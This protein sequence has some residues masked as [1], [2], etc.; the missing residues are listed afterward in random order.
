MGRWIILQLYRET[1]INKNFSKKKSNK[2]NIPSQ[3][4]KKKSIGFVGLDF[5]HPSPNIRNVFIPISDS[6]LERGTLALMFFLIWFDLRISLLISHTNHHIIMIMGRPFPPQKKL[7]KKIYGPA[8]L[9][10]IIFFSLLL[11]LGMLYN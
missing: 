10:H 4:S 8:H 7:K 2:I 6:R 11:L 3:A 9:L 5:V 1:Y